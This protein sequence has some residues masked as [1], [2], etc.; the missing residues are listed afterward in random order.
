MEEDFATQLDR[1]AAQHQRTVAHLEE[2]LSD[3]RHA[4]SA[5]EQH[6]ASLLQAMSQI[7]QQYAQAS[8]PS[9]AVQDKKQLQE[10][11][12][13]LK[14]MVAAESADKSKLQVTFSPGTLVI[15]AAVCVGITQNYGLLA[16]VR[17]SRRQ[18]PRSASI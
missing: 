3:A 4:C 8:T 7:K 5:A 10:Q 16:D 9:K 13:E 18:K 17:G 12:K 11:V 14:L 1:Q 6:A 2:K 15:S